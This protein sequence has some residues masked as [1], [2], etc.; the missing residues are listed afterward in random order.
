LLLLQLNFAKDEASLYRYRAVEL[1]HGR[2]A[3]LGA[4]GYLFAELHHPLYDGRISPGIK[5]LGESHGREAREGETQGKIS[6]RVLVWAASLR[7]R[8]TRV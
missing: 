6:V 2:V 4:L 3:M 1:K 8:L 5:A 7:L